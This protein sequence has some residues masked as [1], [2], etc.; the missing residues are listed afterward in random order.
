MAHTPK[1]SDFAALL[2]NVASAA[3]EAPGDSLPKDLVK[4]L[5]RVTSQSGAVSE[6][7]ATL[8]EARRLYSQ[9]EASEKKLTAKQKQKPQREKALADA[10][11]KSGQSVFEAHQRGDL[12]AHAIFT[13]RLAAEE[14][15]RTAKAEAEATK[16]KPGASFWARTTAAFKSL[17]PSSRVTAAERVCKTAE[18]DLAIK[19]I[20]ADILGTLECKST[21]A[22]IGALRSAHKLVEDTRADIEETVKEKD[23]LIH[24]LKEVCGAKRKDERVPSRIVA[25]LEKNSKEKSIA[26]WASAEDVL[27]GV[28]GVVDGHSPVDHRQLLDAL[29]AALAAFALQFPGSNQDRSKDAEWYVMHECSEQG[30]F[31]TQQLTALIAA[32]VLGRGVR[33][34]QSTDNGW[35]LGL[36]VTHFADS[37]KDAPSISDGGRREWPTGRKATVQITIPPLP[38]LDVQVRLL[39][40]EKELYTFRS[41]TGLPRFDHEVTLDR[42]VY[43]LECQPGMLAPVAIRNYPVTCAIAGHY[44]LDWDNWPNAA[45]VF[46]K[47]AV[48]RK[49]AILPVGVKQTFI[50]EGT[51]RI[52]PSPQRQKHFIGLWEQPGNSAKHVLVTEDGWI[53]MHDGESAKYSWFDKDTVIFEADEDNDEAIFKVASL[54]DRELALVIE[55]KILHFKRGQTLSEKESARLR[56]EAEERAVVLRAKAKQAAAEVGK[57]L[58]KGAAVLALVSVAVVAAAASS[59]GGG[60]GSVGGGGGRGYGG[61]DDDDHS[62]GPSLATRRSPSQ[63]QSEDKRPE[64]QQLGMPQPLRGCVIRKVQER[65][66]RFSHKCE[67]CGTVDGS[68]FSVSRVGIGGTNVMRSSFVCG[69]CKKQQPYE[70]AR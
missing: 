64:K 41:A 60:G 31:P 32:S 39:C 7:A 38:G 25:D 16:A 24:R 1:T 48:G 53:L 70:I 18:Y 15:L 5:D 6:E 46:A 19:A 20:T 61:N 57:G 59:G 29:D 52:A 51:T 2:A 50:L 56:A 55:G 12:Q 4:Q 68:T 14:E 58:L 30:P 28:I 27:V 54:T 23:S 66:V 47:Q 33:V 22:A 67:Y 26:W 9:I 8:T 40:D 10:A 62:G 3:R 37:L 49:D 65:E 42:H 11:E 34:R 45:V 21:K 44:R 35:R 43:V 63:S 36:A 17:G 69:K 13:N